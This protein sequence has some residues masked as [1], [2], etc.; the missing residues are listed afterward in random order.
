MSQI[1]LFRNYENCI[2]AYVTSR[3]KENY[4]KTKV[5]LKMLER[6]LNFWNLFENWSLEDYLIIGILGIKFKNWNFES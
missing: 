5:E 6:K 4:L 2:Y 3:E 1:L